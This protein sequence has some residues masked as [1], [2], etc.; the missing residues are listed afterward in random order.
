MPKMSI[1]IYDT[2]A[3]IKKL[4]VGRSQTNP[5]EPNTSPPTLN[6]KPSTSA[7]RIINPCLQRNH[8]EAAPAQARLHKKHPARFPATKPHTSKIKKLTITATNANFLD[9]KSHMAVILFLN[10]DDRNQFLGGIKMQSYTKLLAA[11]LLT[12]FLSVSLAQQTAGEAETLTFPYMAEITGDN[13]YVRSGPGTNFYYCGRLNKGDKVKVV[14]RQFSWARIVPPPGSFSWISMQYV[15]I[16]PDN[17]TVGTVTGDQ[18][19][20]YAGSDH[21]EPLHST[22]LQGKLDRGDKVKLLGEQMDDYY[23]IAPPSFAYLWVSINFTK[24]LPAEPVKPAPAP[25]DAPA[26]EPQKTKT[27][28]QKPQTP[29]PQP[30]EKAPETET[31]VEPPAPAV[32]EPVVTEETMIEKYKVLQKQLKAE[33]AKP[34][35]EQDYTTIRKELMEMAESE[36]AGKASRYA[37]FLL[38]QVKSLELVLAVDKEVELQ[39]EQLKNIR[40]KIEKN[41][42]E[43][44]AEFKDL[45]EFA[46]VGKLETFTTYGPGHYRILDNTG[47]TIC[48]ARPSGVSQIKLA[49]LIGKKVGLIGTIEPHRQTK[50]TLVRFTKI[51]ELD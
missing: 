10:S 47:R 22:T 28:T 5:F 49:Q 29:E 17:P 34:I 16:D 23:K 20:V 50:G 31:E 45:G 44:L 19:R 37:E 26:V 4:A 51:V 11:V 13:L 42:A 38:K 35:K 24:P 21:V 32:P 15:K 12:S 30:E 25:A 1:N 8:L 39:N 41:R 9:L 36:R 3:Y 18:V 48:Y 46:V 6:N 33:R 7:A 43:K 40:E 2:K 27:Q 14:G